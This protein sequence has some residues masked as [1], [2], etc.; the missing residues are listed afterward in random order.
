MRLQRTV[1]LTA[2]ECCDRPGARR[3]RRPGE[4]EADG[5]DEA[6]RRGRRHSQRACDAAGAETRS[7]ARPSSRGTKG[8]GTQGRDAHG[9]TGGPPEVSTGVETNTLVGGLW[10]VSDFQGRWG[11]QPFHGHGTF[12]YDTSKK[13]YVGIWVDSMSTRSPIPRAITTLPATH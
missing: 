8:S 6:G 9:P 11:S 4:Q 1:F 13:K 10:L 3:G 12:G 2:V 7:G 5:S